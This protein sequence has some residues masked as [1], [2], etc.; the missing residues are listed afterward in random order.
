MCS[1]VN[2]VDIFYADVRG[3]VPDTHYV[4]ALLLLLVIFVNRRG[5]KNTHLQRCK[6]AISLSRV[7]SYDNRGWVKRL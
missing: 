7:A 3:L 1:A 5:I 6:W 2:H 4:V